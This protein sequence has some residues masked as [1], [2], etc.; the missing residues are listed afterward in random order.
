[1]KK[2]A[3]LILAVLFAALALLSIVQGV[4]R[5]VHGQA[6]SRRD[7][8]KTEQSGKE[9]YSESGGYLYAIFIEGWRSIS[10]NVA[11]QRLRR[12][13]RTAGRRI[14]PARLTVLLGLYRLGLTSEIAV[15]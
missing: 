12:F 10:M 8:R 11:W 1:M 15:T 13:G 14:C 9:L 5:G 3:L 6:V 4:R 7:F 2:N